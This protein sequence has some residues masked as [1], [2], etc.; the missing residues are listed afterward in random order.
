MGAAGHEAAGNLRRQMEQQHGDARAATRALVESLEDFVPD[1]IRAE[2]LSP[3]ANPDMVFP[4]TPHK[5]L[6]DVL[7]REP[8]A[9][10][11][12]LTTPASVPD[13]SPPHANTLLGLPCISQ[14]QAK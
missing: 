9:L 2:W 13:R 8:E 3:A 14:L 7:L 5:S 10:L 11:E 6:P 1:T 4:Y 12:T